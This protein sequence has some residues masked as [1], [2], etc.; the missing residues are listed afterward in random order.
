M[1]T[2]DSTVTTAATDK[3]YRTTYDNDRESLSTAVVLALCAVAQ[4]DPTEFQLYRYIDPDALDA[5]FSPIEDVDERCDSV[6]WTAF[7]HRISVHSS[8]EIV[9]RPTESERPSAPG[10]S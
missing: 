1:S 3:T 9:V 7:D 2:K 6:E 10:D 8:G 5:L 4:V